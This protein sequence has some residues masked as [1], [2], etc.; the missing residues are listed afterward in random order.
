MEKKKKSKNTAE[1]G[2]KRVKNGEKSMKNQTWSGFE[3]NC[4]FF[5]IFH[6]LA[7]YF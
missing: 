1:N 5:K 7:D 2:K 6:F 3:L 4:E